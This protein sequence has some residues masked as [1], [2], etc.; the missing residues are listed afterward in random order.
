MPHQ[1]STEIPY[2]SS[3][4]KIPQQKKTLK[5]N[6]HPPDPGDADRGPFGSGSRSSDGDPGPPEI[7]GA[8]GGRLGWLPLAD[9]HYPHGEPLH[10]P[11]GARPG[12]THGYLGGGP[13]ADLL[14][15]HLS[16]G[17]GSAD[18]GVPNLGPDPSLHRYCF[19]PPTMADHDHQALPL[20]YKVPRVP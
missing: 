14:L 16:L 9:G 5:I 19:P 13:L 17:Q 3:E 18:A 10:Q 8:R 12:S 1:Q 6:T 7:G 11:S 4:S 15:R 20:A 2:D